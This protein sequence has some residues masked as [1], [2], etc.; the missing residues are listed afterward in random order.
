MGSH[1]EPPY[2][3]FHIHDRLPIPQINFDFRR[4]WSGAPLDATLE[5][6][7]GVPIVFTDYQYVLRVSSDEYDLLAHLLGNHVMLVDVLHCPDSNDHAPFTKMYHFSNL[8][9]QEF[10]EQTLSHQ[11]VK[12]TFTDMTRV[13]PP[14]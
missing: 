9:Y 5:D 11:M 7:S 14:T 12:V 8:E 3:F 4:S 2:T 1:N 6:D 13:A 10:L